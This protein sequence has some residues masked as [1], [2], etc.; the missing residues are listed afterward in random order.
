MDALTYADF[1]NSVRSDL[2][3]N[4]EYSLATLSPVAGLP[5]ERAEAMFDSLSASDREAI[6]AAYALL[7]QYS[8]VHD[9]LCDDMLSAQ[10]CSKLRQ[11]ALQLDVLGDLRNRA[12]AMRSAHDPS[13]PGATIA[14]KT[15][16]SVWTHPL[17]EPTRLSCR[18]ALVLG[19]GYLPGVAPGECVR[20]TISLED[21]AYKAMVFLCAECSESQVEFWEE[22]MKLYSIRG[23]R[24]YVREPE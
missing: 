6:A 20:R 21:P 14:R 7:D 10:T 1:S 8:T 16:A 3:R 12:W 18:R 23:K 17:P 4:L 15:C 19:V 2:R 9:Q 11:L 13:T 22:R 24:V 5:A